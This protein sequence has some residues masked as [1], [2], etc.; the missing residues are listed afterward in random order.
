MLGELH[1]MPAFRRG[2]AGAKGMATAQVIATDQ[3]TAQVTAQ[4]VTFCQE[5]KSAKEIMAH[6]GLK[7]WKTF[8]SNYLLPLLRAGIVEM[9]IPEKP[10]S[11]RQRYRLAEKGRQVLEEQGKRP[12]S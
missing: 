10:R 1:G 11:S 12:I 9:T 3:V 4:V 6:L 7:H 8:Q 5:A 2:G